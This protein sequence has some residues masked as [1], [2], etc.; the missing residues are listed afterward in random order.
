[1]IE[2]VILP[3][4]DVM[5]CDYMPL[6]HPQGPISKWPQYFHDI[7]HNGPFILSCAKWLVI[8]IFWILEPLMCKFPESVGSLEQLQCWVPPCLHIH[9]RKSCNADFGLF[10]VNELV[11]LTWCQHNQY[12]KA[13][14]AIWR[15]VSGHSKYLEIPTFSIIFAKPGLMAVKLLIL[16]LPYFRSLWLCPMSMLSFSPNCWSRS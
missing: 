9:N 14:S 12:R 8:T 2:H 16:A 4:D 1:M 3:C 13:F 7:L 11:S 6:R 15:S 10:R 5:R